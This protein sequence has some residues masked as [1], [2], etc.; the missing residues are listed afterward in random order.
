MKD[1]FFIHAVNIHQG[2][3][4]RLLNALL[5]AIAP[6]RRVVL[7][8]D[9]RMPIFV[10]LPPCV[11][12]RRIKNSVSARLLVELWLRLKAKK[13]DSVLCFGNLPPL[14][15]LKAFT[16][17]FVQNR[18][19]VEARGL[20]GLKPWTRLRILIERFWFRW[21][22][23]NV[24]QYIVQTS[25]MQSLVRILAKV[26]VPVVVA[27]FIAPC[28]GERNVVAPHVGKLD[29]SMAQ[30]V[31]PAS[32]EV[33]KN[34]RRLIDAWRIL[35]GEGIRPRLLLTL[36]ISVFPLLWNWI[37]EQVLE[38]NLN[39]ENLGLI[40]AAS[41]SVVYSQ[42]EALIYPSLVESFGLPLLE[43]SLAGLAIVAAELDYVRDVAYPKETFDPRSATSIARAV[44][45]F[46]GVQP[47]KPR[48]LSPGEFLKLSMK[49][50]TR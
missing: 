22:A 25:S 47:A 36:D 4:E 13:N 37:R 34:H 17:V 6:Q 2:G 38:H 18:Y 43:A 19:L 28:A 1:T 10:K 24:N 12:V 27:P 26:D 49:R 5:V 45:R 44:K 40:D 33:H 20:N 15:G 21:G 23:R 11:E 30:F 39:V 32:G 35:A 8:V 16:S 42:C 7:N 48:L 50:P 29:E 46:C 9:L 41:M 3:G 31:Y 14:L